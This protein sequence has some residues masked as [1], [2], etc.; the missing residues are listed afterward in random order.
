MQQQGPLE[1]SMQNSVTLEK[2]R[3]MDNRVTIIRNSVQLMEQA[4]KFIEDMQDEFDLRYKTLQSRDPAEKKTDRMKDECTRLQE[5]LNRLD[6]KRKEILSKM[7][8]V[9]KE[10]DSMVTC[11]LHSELLEWKRRQQVSLIGGP[12]LTGLDLLQNWVTEFCMDFS[13]GPC[14]STPAR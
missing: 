7:S 4:V 14:S 3:T 9:I 12:L 1:K 2:Q 11:Q 6:F 10:I 5:M 8:D 13:K